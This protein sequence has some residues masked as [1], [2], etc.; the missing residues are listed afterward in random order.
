M[1][2]TIKIGAL[3]A[4]LA[5]GGMLAFSGQAMADS[6]TMTYDGMSPSTAVRIQ[7]K[8]T[9]SSQTINTTTGLFTFSNV[10][11]PIDTYDDAKVVSFCIDLAD[12][13]SGAGPYTW[14]VQSLA[15]S[16]NP[17]AGPME[18]QKANDLA[19]LLG[20]AITSGV[21]NDARNLAA[22][23]KYALQLAVWEV[24]SETDNAAGYDVRTGDTKFT[25]VS[26]SILNQANVYLG[27]IATA[28]AMTGL[29]GLTS[30]TTQDYVAQ[31]VPI[32]AAAWLFGSA[33]FG[34]AGVGY[35]RGR[36]V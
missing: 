7:T 2:R 4:A 5:I 32:P 24:V 6:V 16:P 19:R 18:A 3:G 33:L 35:R 1:Q 11:G 21:L 22:S 27:E 34:M 8:V 28:T 17:T 30:G 36:R 12:G 23:E 15:G 26:H 13:I 31:V 20:G 10:S 25:N 29:V 9:G 14:E